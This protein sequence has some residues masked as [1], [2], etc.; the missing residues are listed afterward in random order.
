MRNWFRS[1]NDFTS[2]RPHLL[3]SNYYVACEEKFLSSNQFTLFSIIDSID[4]RALS[5]IGLHFPLNKILKIFLELSTKKNKNE[6]FCPVSTY[7]HSLVSHCKLPQVN[8]YFRHENNLLVFHFA[9]HPFFIV[10]LFGVPSSTVSL[11]I[12]FFDKR[13]V[14]CIASA[15]RFL[16]ILTSFPRKFRMKFIST[17][18]KD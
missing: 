18:I 8:V 1:S 13:N 12:I 5:S 15:D 9:F 11:S 7:Y 16:V 14:R 2:Q 17:E 10:F 4:E 6:R 3:R